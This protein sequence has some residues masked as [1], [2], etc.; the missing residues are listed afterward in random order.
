MT[1]MTF[2]H[3]TTQPTSCVGGSTPPSDNQ[4]PFTHCL[5]SSQTVP[6]TPPGSWLNRTGGPLPG[7][8]RGCGKTSK[9][10]LRE[11]TQ[12]PWAIHSSRAHTCTAHRLLGMPSRQIRVRTFDIAFNYCSWQ[13]PVTNFTHI[14]LPGS[15]ILPA[16]FYMYDFLWPHL[17]PLDSGS[18]KFIKCWMVH[19]S[20]E[21]HHNG[22]KSFCYM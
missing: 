22:R 8:L 12:G 18:P 4:Q 15:Y 2:H 11:C 17:L 10:M 13:I 9:V 7:Q 16:K 14:M 19:T 1:S 20:W 5:S 21:I 6:T 3:T